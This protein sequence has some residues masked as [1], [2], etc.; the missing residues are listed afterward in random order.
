MAT[1]SYTQRERGEFSLPGMLRQLSTENFRGSFE[2]EICEDAALRAGLDFDRTKPCI[3]WAMLTGKR[4]MTAA[5]SSGS[6]YLMDSPVSPVVEALFPWSAVIR[7]G[8]TTMD[9]LSATAAVPRITT[10]AA[11]TW[12][13]TE[14]TAI[15]ETQP[16]IGQLVLTPKHAGAYIE[17]SRLLAMAS[18][19]DVFLRGHLLNTTGA[20]VD[21]ALLQG[22][23]S[24]GQPQG[25]LGTSGV[26]TVSGTSLAW[27]TG[28]AEMLRLCEVANAQPNGFLMAGDTAKILRGRERFTGAGAIFDDG[29][30]DGRAAH[31]T[32]AAPD[33]AIFCGD[34]TRAVLATW[35]PGPVVEVNPYAGFTAG[36]NAMRIVLACDVG[37]LTPAA[38][39]TSSSVT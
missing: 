37:L 34:W 17:I 9:N 20:M 29:A 33:G 16:T 39:C 2:A 38:F 36:I 35:G 12:L 1:R 28:I 14:A 24:S 23:G 13:S 5:G 8:I 7:A 19:A 22:S 27:A 6:N 25:I 10:S 4:D 32:T 21:T 26:G 31:V 11:G 30:I 18:D 3:P 15:T